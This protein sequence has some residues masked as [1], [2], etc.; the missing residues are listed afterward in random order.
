MK[1]INDLNTTTPLDLLNEGKTWLSIW[2]LKKNENLFIAI[3]CL[4]TAF[5][6]YLK[7]HLV[8]KNSEY[9]NTEK[10]KILGHNFNTLFEKITAIKNDK[11]NN[12]FTKE[13][14]Q[15]ID[16]YELWTI[17]IDRLKYPEDRRMWTI[18]QGFEKREHTLVDI[19]RKIDEEITSNKDKWLNDTYPK[20]VELSAM[21]QTGFE[22]NP[23]E[24]DLQSLSNICSKCF[25]VN[26]IL[27]EKYNFPWD[28][29]KIPY[30]N[31]IKCKDFFDPNL[32]RQN[33]SEE[34]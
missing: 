15:Q 24:I 28:K 18:E 31:C 11:E 21:I 1:P 3:Y 20:K 26:I 4:F 5:E 16:K 10:L 9:K 25:P 23:E 6:F 19:L 32:M 33:M 2:E 30:K 22:G 13:I 12:K 29:D 27:F 14:K 17:E 7:A 34:S 8:F